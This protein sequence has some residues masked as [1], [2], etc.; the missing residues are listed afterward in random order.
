MIIFI[1]LKLIKAINSKF[2]IFDKFSASNCGWIIKEIKLVNLD[3]KLNLI[4][5][6]S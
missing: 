4:R 2:Y 5:L 1:L 6:L 3:V